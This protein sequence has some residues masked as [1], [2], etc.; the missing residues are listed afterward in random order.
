MELALN[1]VAALLT[2]DLGGHEREP[3][4]LANGFGQEPTRCGLARRSLSSVRKRGAVRPLQ[5]FEDLLGLAP[6]P[7]ARFLLG[8]FGGLRAL[9]GLLSGCRARAG[10]E[11]LFFSIR[12]RHREF[13]LR[14]NHRGQDI[15]R[16]G[17]EDKQANSV[18]RGD[19][20]A[21]MRLGAQIASGG[22]R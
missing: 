21:M 20:I 15:H 2:L 13:S 5:K 3:E 16:S 18:G 14:G 6:L 9:G 8:G 22:I 17:R 4:F 7:R 19:G 1:R 12:R 11:G 10:L